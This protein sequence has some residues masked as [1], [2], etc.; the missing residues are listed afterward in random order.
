MLVSTKWKHYCCS[1]DKHLLVILIHYFHSHII[2][3]VLIVPSKSSHLM[4]RRARHFS[5]SWLLFILKI[6]IF[7]T[8]FP[9][10]VSM[11]LFF[12]DIQR[13]KV[14]FPTTFNMST[15]T[16]YNLSVQYCDANHGEFVLLLPLLFYVL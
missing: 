11:I 1:L 6:H 14:Q 8:T 9:K 13:Q 7:C 3:P 12:L 2:E 15:I 10:L 4:P 16:N 5:T